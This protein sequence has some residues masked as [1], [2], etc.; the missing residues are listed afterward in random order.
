MLRKARGVIIDLRSN[1]GGDAEA[2]ADIATT[3]LPESTGLGQFTDRLGNVSLKLA[4]GGS[5]FYNSRTAKP[6]RAPI[7]VLASER[8][9]SAAEIFISALK[10]ANHV[11][12]I[13]AQT[14]GCVLAVRMHHTLPDGGDLAVSELDYQTARGDRLEG[15]GIV[16]DI[17]V[18]QTRQDLYAGRDPSME[19]AFTNLRRSS[20]H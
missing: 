13:G 16:P 5:A 9:S 1:G 11:T 17:A 8:T 18:S 14:C 19:S 20:H 3:F 6:M 2:M 15:N 10:Q 7:I 4:T 12:V